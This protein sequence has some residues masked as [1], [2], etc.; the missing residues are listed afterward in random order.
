MFFTGFASLHRPFLTSAQLIYISTSVSLCQ[1]LFSFSFEN[2]F[3]VDLEAPV[4]FC[5]S[6]SSLH[7][8]LPK[9]PF[10]NT[11]FEF[12]RRLF[13]FVNFIHFPTIPCG[14]PRPCIQPVGHFDRTYSH[15][16]ELRE[17]SRRLWQ[18]STE[19]IKPGDV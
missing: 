10:V 2:V 16:A 8:I 5:F 9:S 19:Q 7:I 13:L 1:A 11:F 4:F 17:K 12:F 18:N 3:G 15:L 14:F 6:R